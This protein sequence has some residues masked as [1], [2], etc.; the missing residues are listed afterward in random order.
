[1]KKKVLIMTYCLQYGGVE[2]ALVNMLKNIDYNK[3]EVDVLITDNINYYANEIPKEVNII[4]SKLKSLKELFSLYLKKFKFLK[5]LKIL[6]IRLFSSDIQ[7]VET[8]LQSIKFNN[9][10]MYDYAIAY[11]SNFQV[12]YICNHVQAKK[13]IMFVHSN[14]AT[15][16]KGT[17]KYLKIYEKM[18]LICCVSSG[19]ADKLVEMD[20]KL[21]GKISIMPNAIDIEKIKKLAEKGET[22]EDEYSG[23]R[24]L[25]VGRLASE[26]GYEMAMKV[27]R[28]LIDNQ[29]NVRWY[30]IGDGY[31]K[32]QIEQ[33]IKKQDLEKYCVLL[34]AKKNP[35]KYMEDC[36]IYVQ[37]SLDET[38]C[39][40]T[41]EA[42]IFNKPIVRTNTSGA[43]EQ[44]VNMKNGII[45]D[46]SIDGIYNGIVK[47]IDDEKL[48][49]DI[50]YNLTKEDKK[51]NCIDQ[52]AKIEKIL[53]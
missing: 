49:K 21:V 43:K 26:K 44:F 2:I 23:I 22:F 53:G 30:I 9:E 36:D 51:N 13:K 34:G 27:L 18:D 25:T 31:F 14:P 46:I 1:M 19:V 17:E 5:A 28:K 8:V 3:Y 40:T 47:Y 39:I 48:K 37:P 16:V 20:E 38:Y 29:Y 35:Y 42:K 4:F 11:H 33:E 50:I 15:D 32:K 10:K 12:Q 7:K 6:K 41:E 52:I 24:I 45:T